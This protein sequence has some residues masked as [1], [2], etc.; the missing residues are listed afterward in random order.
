VLNTKLGYL[1]SGLTQNSIMVN[2]EFWTTPSLS[3]WHTSLSFSWIV[4]VPAPVGIVIAN[5]YR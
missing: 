5:R 4:I 2:L 3:W 1:D